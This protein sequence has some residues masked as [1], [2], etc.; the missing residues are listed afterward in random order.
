MKSSLARGVGIFLDIS[1]S[2]KNFF[3]FVKYLALQLK[4]FF[5]FG[6]RVGVLGNFTVVNSK[7]V[8]IGKNCGINHDVFILGNNNIEIGDGVVLSARVML[9]DAGLDV[10]KFS[11][12]DFPPHVSGFVK[13]ED[14]VWVGAGA[15]VLS[16]VTIGRKSVIG[17]GSVVTKDVSPFTIVAGNPARP[18]GRTDV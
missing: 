3:C 17:A 10:K 2:M 18:I 6:R 7:N 14:G 9:L 1:L 16:G 8:C 4:G 11:T 15:I 12:Q 5:V 13:I